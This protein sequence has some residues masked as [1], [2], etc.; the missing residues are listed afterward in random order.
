MKKANVIILSGQSNAVGCSEVD[1]LPEHFPKERIQ[2]W[3]NG[4]ENVKINYFSHDKKS[5]GFVKTTFNCTVL[6]DNTFGLEVGIAEALTE[7]YPD[8]EFFIVKCAYGGVTLYHDFCS[9]SAGMKYD[10]LSFADQKPSITDM[11]D[12]ND[13]PRAGWCYNELT[14]IISE[15]IETLENKGYSPVIKAFC[16]MQGESDANMEDATSTY[17]YNYDAFL[18]DIKARFYNYFDKCLFI[19]AG[20]STVWERYERINEIKRKYAEKRSD[21]IFLDTIAANL[22]TANEPRDNPDIGHYDSDSLIKLGRMFGES[23]KI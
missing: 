22:T 20:I 6:T 14:K 1:Y 7:K 11:Y 10:P 13:P 17:A 23:I 3:Q 19:D 15:S 12:P 4:Y 18:R 21:C 5:G 8:E 9:P 2:T 16:W